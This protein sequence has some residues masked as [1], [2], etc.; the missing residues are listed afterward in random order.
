MATHKLKAKEKK[1]KTHD[2][3]I[4]DDGGLEEEKK[5]KEKK[6]KEKKENVAPLTA[7]G[8][9]TLLDVSGGPW[10][11]LKCPSFGSSKPPILCHATEPKS[12]ERYPQGIFILKGIIDITQLL[13]E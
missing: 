1:K 5:G 9:P 8:Q 12:C 6:G 13:K 2:I 10:L 7:G 3:F 4:H 11:V